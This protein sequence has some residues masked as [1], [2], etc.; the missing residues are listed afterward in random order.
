MASAALGLLLASCSFA[1]TLALRSRS[2]NCTSWHCLE[3][4]VRKPDDSFTF[5]KLGDASGSENS[6]AWSASF[7]NMTSQKWLSN[8]EVN[9]PV[10]W[11]VIFVVTPANFGYLGNDSKDWA[12]VYVAQG[13]Y[14]ATGTVSA[15]PSEMEVAARMAVRTGTVVAAVFQVPFQ[16][17]TYLMDNNTQKFEEDMKA[18]GWGMALRHPEKPE[19]ALEFPM[20]KAVVR[21]I[22]TLQ[23][24]SQGGLRR[25]AV[26]G[27]S[28]RALVSWL[29]G[30]IDERVRAVMVACHPLALQKHAHDAHRSYEHPV[31][32]AQPYTHVGLGGK[33]DSAEANLL[34]SKMDLVS[35]AAFA[36]KVD[37]LDKLI[38]EAGND[39]FAVI[40]SI[41]NWYGQLGGEKSY[42]MQPN[43]SHMGTYVN[44]P[45]FPKVLSWLTGLLTKQSTP[46]IAVELNNRTGSIVV[47]QLSAHRAAVVKLWTADSC[48]AHGRRD[49]RFHSKDNQTVCQAC[50]GHF[51]AEQGVCE[52]AYSSWSSREL[53]QGH[54]GSWQATVA[55]PEAG[56]YRV[57]LVELSYPGPMEAEP[58]VLTSEPLV[59][60]EGYPY[61][62]CQ[63]EDCNDDSKL[64]VLLQH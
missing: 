60:P 36:A 19:Y 3:D 6:V 8:T 55:A 63:G 11:H 9:R 26:T 46:K 64:L 54:D 7:L 29:T 12:T 28:K 24:V 31:F 59:M 57:G 37:R 32:V 49:F 5:T 56:G 40:D 34:Y 4:Y 61:K 38:M 50:N 27:F 62:D 30:A 15:T 17:T 18:F 2:A 42:F 48:P 22:D 13:Q 47:R 39:D 43:S 53:Q 20:V 41:H 58:W 16:P 35:N 25:F 1:Q 10:W 45:I 44:N 23:L 52:S 51:D 14:D 21:T 33:Q